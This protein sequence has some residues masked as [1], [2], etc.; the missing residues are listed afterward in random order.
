MLACLSKNATIV[1]RRLARSSS[2]AG[3]D[4][5]GGGGG[6]GDAGGG[7][8]VAPVPYRNSKLTHF[9]KVGCSGGGV[10]WVCGVIYGYS[11][12]SHGESC[13]FSIIFWYVLQSS[14]INKESNSQFSSIAAD[15]F[16]AT[17]TIALEHHQS[18]EMSRERSTRR[19]W[20]LVP[21]PFPSLALFARLVTRL[22]LPTL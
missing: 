11:C 14:C 12:Y 3:G 1:S 18:G 20:L 22:R 21:C 15:Y 6:N 10:G 17:K 8:M 2:S 5:G 4:G 19:V 9:L 13:R 7:E 16:G